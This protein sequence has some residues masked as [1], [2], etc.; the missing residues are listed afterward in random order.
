MRHGVN[1]E[2]DCPD[3]AGY[4]WWRDDYIPEMGV[5]IPVLVS[6]DWR[7]FIADDKEDKWIRLKWV[8]GSGGGGG[9][10]RKIPEPPDW[11]MPHIDQDQAPQGSGASAA[12]KT[13]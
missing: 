11:E 12:R 10:W 6:E 9:R 7:V 8:D 5:W 2:R 1:E 3:E 13:L 4:W